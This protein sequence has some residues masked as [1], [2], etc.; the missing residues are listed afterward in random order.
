MSTLEPPVEIQTQ[1]AF[2]KYR[3]SSNRRR[4]SA[5]S[6]SSTPSLVGSFTSSCSDN[7]P[8][9]STPGTPHEFHNSAY[10]WDPNPKEN[11]QVPAPDYDSRWSKTYHQESS[12]THRRNYS[13]TKSCNVSRGSQQPAYKVQ[14]RERA[15]PKNISGQA[16][17][18]EK[19]TDEEN[20]FLIYFRVDHPLSWQQ[21]EA[22]YNR[23]FPE[24][25]R[26]YRTDGGLQSQFY[27]QNTVCPEMTDDKLLVFG[28]T[29][30]HEAQIKEAHET[31]D[32]TL[33]LSFNEYDNMTFDCKVRLGGKVSLIDRY[34]EQ[35][36][37]CDYPWMTEQDKTEA[38]RLGESF[39]SYTF[40]A[41]GHL[42]TSYPAAL[43]HPYRLAWEARKASKQNNTSS[44]SQC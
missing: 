28:P 34:A 26:P 29:E 6:I 36:A 16:H 30:E 37:E 21:L 39:L 31:K 33:M 44:Q 5:D 1:D 2:E 17:C 11:L 4:G 20:R 24:G 40:N 42:L 38:R 7:T 35:I 10:L 13:T 25:T 12:R 18:N 32:K 43:R 23:R 15:R 8:P 27:R 19:Y 3:S 41:L 9:A 14:R 22:E